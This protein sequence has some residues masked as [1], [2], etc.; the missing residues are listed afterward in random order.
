[1]RGDARLLEQALVNLLLNACDACRRGGRVTVGVATDGASVTF[2]VTDDGAGIRPEHA[3][4]VLE[5]FF[6]TK[7]SDQGTGLG[8]SITKEIVAIHR[9]TLALEP[10]APQGTRATIRVPTE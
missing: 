3:A 10:G 8:L 4:R 7:P 9:G 1:M 2:T 6:S 5:P